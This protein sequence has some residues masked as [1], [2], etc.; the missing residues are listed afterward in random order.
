M[1]VVSGARVRG[2]TL[3]CRYAY[4]CTADDLSAVMLIVRRFLRFP[5]HA[6]PHTQL[7]DPLFSARIVA[8]RTRRSSAR[9]V[10]RNLSF[11]S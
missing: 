3:H 10:H 7:V 4:G 8:N 5:I 9:D 1:R 6:S 2:V 11:S